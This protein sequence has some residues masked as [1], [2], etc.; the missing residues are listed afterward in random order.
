MIDI[1]LFI[2]ISLS[3]V[4]VTLSIVFIFREREFEDKRLRGSVNTLLIGMLFLA[5]FLLAKTVEY[6]LGFFEIDISYYSSLFE[7]V[8]ISLMVVCFL[9]SMILMREL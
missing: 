1:V 8:C 5:I 9:V 6:L 3:F 2:L 4:F 7:L